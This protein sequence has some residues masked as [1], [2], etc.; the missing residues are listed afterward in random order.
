MCC[1]AQTIG[2]WTALGQGNVQGEQ[3]PGNGDGGHGARGTTI[4]DCR[5]AL[6]DA[7]SACEQPA[8]ERHRNLTNHRVLTLAYDPVGFV[9][10]VTIT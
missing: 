8:S 2:C 7:S 3:Y 1:L 9:M 5:A 6:G 4:A 10:A